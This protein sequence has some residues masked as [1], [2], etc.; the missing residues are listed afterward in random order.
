MTDDTATATKA[1][2]THPPRARREFLAAIVGAGAGAAAIALAAPAAVLGAPPGPPTPTFTSNDA[3]PALRARNT[4]D[5]NAIEALGSGAQD[6]DAVSIAR[7]NGPGMGLAVRREGEAGGFGVWIER[8][9]SGEGHGL[10]GSRIDNGGGSGVVGVRSGDGGG[11]GVEGVHDGTEGNA[12]LAFRSG[13]GDGQGIEAY[14]L[15]EGNG[16]AIIAAREGAGFG[17]GIEAYRRD[18]GNGHALVATREGSG[19]G[20]AVH[21]IGDVGLVVEGRSKFIT[22]GFRTIPGDAD[23]VTVSDVFVS[24]ASHVSV[25]LT[26]NPG[27]PVA[28]SWVDRGEGEFTVHLTGQVVDETEISFF[29]ADSL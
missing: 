14:R 16:T 28:I 8:N 2:L 13:S 20:A 15:D 21:A 22:V 10:Y 4:A 6:T 24:G 26:S 12:I 25:S 27:A 19:E 9:G 17:H 3:D 29:I 1:D 7:V 5:G 18:G 11:H 23:H